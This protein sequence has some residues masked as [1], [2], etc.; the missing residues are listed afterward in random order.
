MFLFSFKTL[1]YVYLV[2]QTHTKRHCALEKIGI[3]IVKIIFLN[4]INHKGKKTTDINLINRACDHIRWHSVLKS[5]TTVSFK[6][7][8]SLYEKNNKIKAKGEIPPIQGN[9]NELGKFWN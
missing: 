6:P 4:N 5:H 1:Y 3:D 7:G 2:T 8:L 9:N